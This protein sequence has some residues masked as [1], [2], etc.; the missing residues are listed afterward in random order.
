[1]KTAYEIGYAE[2][3]RHGYFVTKRER[4]EL[5][6]AAG[7]YPATDQ[8]VAEFQRGLGAGSDSFQQKLEAQTREILGDGPYWRLSAEHT[9]GKSVGHCCTCGVY[10][11]PTASWEAVIS[12]ATEEAAQE[13]GESLLAEV[14]E[15]AEV[16]NCNRQLK[17]GSNDWWN[18]V[19][20]SAVG[21]DNLSEVHPSL[22]VTS[23]TTD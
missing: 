20:V 9:S 5:L 14:V 12:A 18:S 10:D 17:P 21:V 2:G 15:E 7:F 16:C 23:G 11:D 3:K 22:A 19:A 13:I 6:V 4:K 8:S 1:M